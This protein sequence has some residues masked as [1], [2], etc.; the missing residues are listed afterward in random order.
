MSVG[1]FFTKLLL[2]ASPAI[3]AAIFH[4]FFVRFNWL[5]FMKHPLDF[6]RQFRGQRIFGD[7]KTFRGVFVMVLLS[8]FFTYSVK[9]FAGA[10]PTIRPYVML[11]FSS[12]T[13]LFYGLLYGLGYS[14]AE[15]PNSFLK[16]QMNIE[17]GKR[18]SIINIILDQADSVLGCFL[19]LLPF[20]DFTFTFMLLGVFVLTLV[21]LF[22]NYTLYILGL[23]KNPL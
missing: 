3:L 18:G 21:H 15:L 2:I 7:N 8:V 6:G 10:Y 22:F 23:R 14:L 16:R 11:D 5:C 12:Y 19:L 4:M 20:A 9:F 17:E 1:S 13:P